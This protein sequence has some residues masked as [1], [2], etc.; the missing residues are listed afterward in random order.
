MTT[1]PL[2]K[3]IQHLLDIHISKG[4]Y[5]LFQNYKDKLT[6][7]MGLFDESRLS[8]FL[9]IFT[10]SRDGEGNH[11]PVTGLEFSD[12]FPFDEVLRFFCKR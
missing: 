11:T 6:G 7:C 5:F 3:Q 12:Y 1:N 9:V 4:F 8:D 10:L 2:R